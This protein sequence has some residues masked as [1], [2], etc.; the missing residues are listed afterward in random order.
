ME[1]LSKKT[2]KQLI[3]RMKKIMREN[4]HLDIRPKSY[5]EEMKILDA[6]MDKRNIPLTKRV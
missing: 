5:I 4:V 6:E 3:D 2:D 1:D